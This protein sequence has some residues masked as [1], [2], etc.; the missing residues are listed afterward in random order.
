M[1]DKEGGFY[2][3]EDADSLASTEAHEKA[4]GAFYVWTKAELDAALGDD[5]P[6]FNR[7]YG[8]E[9]EGNS[10]AGSDPLGELKGK[11][12]L[13]QRLT[14]ASAAK[15]FGKSDAEIEQVLD[16][17]RKKLFELRS[18][19]PRPHLD[20]KVIV[21]WN[22]LMISALARGAQVLDEPR[23]LQ[24]AQRSAKFIQTRLWK[25]GALIRSFRHE[26][27][28]IAGFSDDYATLI[29]GL[30]DLYEADFDPQ[31]LEWSLAL[32][33]KMDE[34]FYDRE[35][36]G[37]FQTPPGLSDVLFRTKEDYDGAEATQSS[38]AAGYLLR[39]AQLTDSKEFRERAEKTIKSVGEQLD[40]AP[41]AVAQMLCAVDFSAAKPRQ[42]VIA[43][44]RDAEDT[45]ALLRE[46]RAV[47]EP[48]Q[49]VLLADSGP[50]Q[51]WLGK[52]LET[53]QGM[54]PVNGKAAAYVCENFVCQAPETDPAKLREMLRK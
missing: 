49:I 29:Q 35:H 41:S 52:R 43:G 25:D 34:L 53:V 33:A 1:T 11:N 2:S 16:R 47:F 48:N 6:I 3:A 24:A 38:V 22:G 50:S 44:A 42:V 54:K 32:Q 15:L 10:P 39:L 13:I 23:Y 46:V 12:T 4:E 21:A 9:A 26:P 18:K 51:A 20:D 45:R 37:Y 36:G 8:V 27:S 19:R 40:K 7:F 28:K 5:A 14:V 31:W 30:L 17:S